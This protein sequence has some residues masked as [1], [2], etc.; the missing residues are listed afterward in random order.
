MQAGSL[1]YHFDNREHLVAE[2]LRLGIESA[3]AI[4]DDAL[5]HAPPAATPLDRLE[6]AIR[7]HAYAVLEMSDYAAANSRIF[8]TTTEPVREEHYSHQ[9]RYGEFFHTLFTAAVA[10]G[11]LR[12]ELD[13]PVIRMLLFGAMNWSAEWYRPGRG[14]A[15]DHVIEQLVLMALG[16]LVTENHRH[17]YAPSGATAG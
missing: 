2:V 12:E 13:L 15:A 14:R 5:A 7:A 1:Y 3:W 6:L 10:S 17:R 8:P 11:Q 4:V 16:G 9:Q